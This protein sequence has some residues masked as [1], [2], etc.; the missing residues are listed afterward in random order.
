MKKLFFPLLA[1]ILGLEQPQSWTGRA[2]PVFE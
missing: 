2:M 1:A